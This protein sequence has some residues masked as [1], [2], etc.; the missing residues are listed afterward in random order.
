MASQLIVLAVIEK[1]G[2]A[3][4]AMKP[5][6]E[7]IGLEWSSQRTKLANNK[8]KFSYVDINTTGKDSK[9]YQMLCIP[10]KKLNGYLFSINPEKVREDIMNFVENN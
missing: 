6:V 7:G 2:G 8:G 3:Y 10:L 5:I 4:V 9:Q 1:D